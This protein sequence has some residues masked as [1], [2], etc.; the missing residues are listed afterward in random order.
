MVKNFW[1]DNNELVIVYRNGTHHVIE[2]YEDYN[3]VFTGKIED[4]LTYCKN[5]EIA[6]MESIIGQS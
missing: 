2:A 4:C 3:T 6:Y 1:L 5:R